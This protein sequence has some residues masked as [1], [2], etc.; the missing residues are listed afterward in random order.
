MSTVYE[1]ATQNVE[2][3]LLYKVFIPLT[4][5]WRVEMFLL[6]EFVAKYDYLIFK[7]LYLNVSQMI[8]RFWIL[9]IDFL[10]NDKDDAASDTRSRITRRSASFVVLT[11]EIIFISVNDDGSSQN[12]IG[13]AE[14]DHVVHHVDG[15]HSGGIS[16]NVA[17]ITGV[18]TGNVVL[19]GSVKDIGRIEMFTGRIASV[20]ENVTKFVNVESVFAWRQS[21][22]GPEDSQHTGTFREIEDTFDRWITGKMNSSCFCAAE[23]KHLQ[24]QKCRQ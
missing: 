24:Q 20:G 18:S 2:Q 11:T 16:H 17:E 3:F 4:F 8:S 14:C 1:G 22:D 5:F 10:R 15:S 21:R 12:G 7:F 6:P 23:L 13:P 19:L 9:Y